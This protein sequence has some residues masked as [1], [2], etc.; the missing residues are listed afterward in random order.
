[1]F[2]FERHVFVMTGSLHRH[3]NVTQMSEPYR[4]LMF[5]FYTKQELSSNELKKIWDQS[6]RFGDH[7]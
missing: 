7:G 6:D 2:P 5:N 4:K 1:M 3:T